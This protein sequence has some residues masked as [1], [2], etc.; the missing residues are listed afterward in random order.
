MSLLIMNYCI[1]QAYVESYT[2]TL[3][4]T[5]CKYKTLYIAIINML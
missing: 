1:V 4:A 2:I 5:L 3:Q